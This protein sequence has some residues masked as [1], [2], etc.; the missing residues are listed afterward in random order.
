MKNNTPVGLV[1]G[2]GNCLWQ[3]CGAYACRPEDGHDLKF[4]ACDRAS[5]QALTTF[6]RKERYTH[7]D[8]CTAP[9][10]YWQN[11]RWLLSP[12]VIKQHILV[13]D[14]NKY[15]NSAVLQHSL[16]VHV[17]GGDFLTSKAHAQ[18]RMSRR[19]IDSAL[20]HIP[21][22]DH[23]SVALVTDDFGYVTHLFGSKYPVLGDIRDPRVAFSTLCAAKNLL[24]SPGS[25]FSWWA[26]YL[27]EH[28][29]VFFPEKYWPQDIG[30]LATDITSC[31][32]GVGLIPATCKDSWTVLAV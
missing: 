1:G 27:G 16:V 26:A 2:L 11:T 13:S 5:N 22:A 15:S 6:V 21:G 19:L 30:A 12:E 9:V 10:G 24:V 17:R 20:E 8:V 4:V 14:V 7:A 32:T 25:S 31:N 29:H 28:E 3:I 18:S 23:E